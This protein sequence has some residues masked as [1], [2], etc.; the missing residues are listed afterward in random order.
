MN[1]SAAQ[2][3]KTGLFVLVSLLLL[4]A[5]IFVISKQ[6]KLFGDT[7]LVKV[8]FKNI[9]GT[10][11]GNFVRFAGINIGT[12]ETIQIINDST[13][14]L[15]LNI[16]K[17]VQTYI[18]SDAIASIGSD[19]LMGDKLIM[20]SAG[21]SGSAPVKNGGMLQGNNP[22]NVDKVLSNLS[23]VT[24]NA[25]AITE[26]LAGIIEKVNSGKGSIG[27]LLTD[28]KLAKD[29]EKTI[30]TAKTT[31]SNVS[32]TA[33]TVNENMEAAQSSFLL[34]GYFRKKEKKRI[35]DSIENVK[36]MPETI[37]QEPV[38]KEK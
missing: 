16:E 18:K 25:M 5:L 13:V 15:E 3:T 29:M 37:K 11:E 19:G 24:D 26:G 22:I 31:A 34:K 30:E 10:K 27:R 7:F 4:L 28:D 35:K 23:K 6:K 2:K 21:N 38:K 32:K 8:Q 36:K 12:V 17:N 9:A 20:I 33:T 1:I 14:Q